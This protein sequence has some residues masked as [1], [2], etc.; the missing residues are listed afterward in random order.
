M[1]PTVDGRHS[2]PVD[3]TNILLFTG[4]YTSK[5]WLALGFLNHHPYVRFWDVCSTWQVMAA[6]IDLLSGIVAG[7]QGRI[8]EVPFRCSS[9]GMV[10]VSTMNT[11]KIN[12]SSIGKYTIHG[13]YG[14]WYIY[15]HEWFFLYLLHVG[16]CT[17]YIECVGCATGNIATV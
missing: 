6:S 12:H 15:L 16:K 5:R 8:S 10:Y 14:L 4:F 7:L 13:S 17:L 2:A 3:M 11:M 1:D 9:M